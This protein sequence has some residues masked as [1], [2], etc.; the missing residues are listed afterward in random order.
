MSKLPSDLKLIVSC[1]TVV[2]VES[3]KTILE[4]EWPVLHVPKESVIAASNVQNVMGD[5]MLLLSGAIKMSHKV[6]S[7]YR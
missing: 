4:D 2:Y 3:R 6:F 7:I 5:I 1:T